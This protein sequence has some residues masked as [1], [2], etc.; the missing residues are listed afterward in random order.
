MV[1]TEIKINRATVADADLI[2]TLSEITFRETYQ[3]SCSE[4]D[5]DRFIHKCFSVQAIWDELSDENDYYFIARIGNE[6]A[7]YIRLKEDYTDYPAMK[8]YIALE[9]KRIYVLQ[10]L[11]GKKVG[12]TLM[13]GAFQLMLEKKFEA[14]WLG[15]WEFNEKALLFYNSWGFEDTGFRHTFYIG[16][17]AQTDHWLI[18]T[19]A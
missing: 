5:M 8:K 6:P 11:Q 4:E 2:A 7:G 3:G 13:K 14:I 10:Q 12:A 15:V 9:L 17:T 19:S 1:I 18:R 16:D